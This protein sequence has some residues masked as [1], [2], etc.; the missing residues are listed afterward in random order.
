MSSNLN[1]GEDLAIKSEYFIL[2]KSLVGKVLSE[3]T[4]SKQKVIIGIGG[5][6]GSG[7]STTAYCLEHEL[8]Q[9]GFKS[10]TIHM[11]SY[12]KLPP[13]DNHQ[14]RIKSLK[15]VGPQEVNMMLL[16]SHLK[17]FTNNQESIKIPVV[18]YEKN[19]F[20]SRH[21]DLSD[22]NVLIIEGVYAFLLDHL[23]LRVFLKRTYRDTLEDRRK[24]TR[25]HYDPLIESILDIEHNIVSPMIADADYVIEK[26]YTIV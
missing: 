3:H 2:T 1:I 19:S 11:D 25:E 4:L 17:A 12:F 7:K 20:S 13:Q 9:Q 18:S 26:N 6:S 16:N 24:R 5:E 21:I 8:T 23:D 14:Q 15:N 10:S 22:L